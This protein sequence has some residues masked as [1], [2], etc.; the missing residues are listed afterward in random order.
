MSLK[1]VS[2]RY[3]PLVRAEKMSTCSELATQK[4]CGATGENSTCVG[5]AL[6]RKMSG[7]VYLRHADASADEPGRRVGWIGVFPK[8][9]MRAEEEDADDL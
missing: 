8:S 1:R 9:A 6:C 4:S 3:T 7:L 2:V 5:A